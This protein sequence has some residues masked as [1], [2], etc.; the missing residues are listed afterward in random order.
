[1]ISF[2]QFISEQSEVNSH[3]QHMEDRVWDSGVDG[4][5]QVI[6]YAQTLRDQLSGNSKKSMNVSVKFDGSPAIF[7]G[8]DPRDGKFFVAKKGI[9]NV[10][11]KVYKTPADIDADTSGDLNDKLKLALEH[12]PKLG[13]KGIIQGD[14]LYAKKDLKHVTIDGKSYVTF[15]PNTIAYAI[16]EESALAQ[17]ILRSDVGVVWHTVYTG[18]DFGSLKANFG[19]E[20]ASSLKKVNSVWSIDAVFKDVSGS[21]SM[22]K[23]ETVEVTKALS[24]AGRVF[25]QISKDTFDLFAGH[26]ELNIKVNTFINSKVRQGKQID[27][28]ANFVRDLKQFIV[29]Y[30]QKEADKKKT[31][32]GKST[33]FEKRDL[34]HSAIDSVDSNELTA[35]VNLYN[36]LVEIKMM[37]VR[38]LNQAS[39]LGTF[40]LT[41][42]GYE[43]TSPEGFVAMDSVGK[44]AVKFVDRLSFSPANF[45]SDVKK[46]WQR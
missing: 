31:D 16:P 36:K 26:S 13:I 46:G 20:I 18:S 29:D 34:L 1:M 39:R 40:L 4:V 17:K 6:T 27:N 37:F 2:K 24:E 21:A 25:N 5:R 43:V 10:N 41:D 32:K 35:M 12:F 23:E 7:C 38:K 19:R 30:Y 15:H 42:K 9:F 28:P 8:I 45:S 44:G 33:S 14:F 11:P 3:M 22:T